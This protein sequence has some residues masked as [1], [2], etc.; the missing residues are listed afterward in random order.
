MLVSDRFFLTIGFVALAA[1][2][3]WLLSLDSADTADAYEAMARA[4]ID[5]SGASVAVVLQRSDCQQFLGELAELSRYHNTGELLV[6]GFVVDAKDAREIAD[7]LEGARLSFPLR[8]AANNTGIV[9]AVRAIGY[10]ATPLV[11]VFDGS[12]RLRAASPWNDVQLPGRG[13]RAIEVALELAAEAKDV[14]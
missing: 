8:A 11:L 9:K 1:T 13:M 12:G 6:I 5:D 2:A 7:A 3:G 10:R 14:R 4:G